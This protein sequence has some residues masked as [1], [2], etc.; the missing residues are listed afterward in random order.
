MNT[1]PF[2]TPQ[3]HNTLFF[4]VLIAERYVEAVLWQVHEGKIEIISQSAQNPW[5][6]DD[7]C[8]K[9]IDRSLQ[10]LGQLEEHVHQTLFAL[11]S[12]WVNSEGILASKKPLFQ[13]ITKE[14]ALEA[15]GFVVT[16]EALV[17]HLARTTSS[18]LTLFLLDFTDAAVNVILVK[19]G[20]IV[21]LEKVGRSG[22]TVSD[23]TEA[24]AHFQ[25]KVFPSKILLFSTFLSPEEISK[26]QQ[27][28]I[29]YTWESAY[30]FLHPPLVEI[31]ASQEIMN[32]VVQSGGMAVSEARGL[33][34][35]AAP[36]AAAPTHH[37]APAD[38]FGFKNTEAPP[39]KEIITQSLATI[40]PTQPP[41][42]EVK[43]KK[44]TNHLFFIFLGVLGGILVL[45]GVFYI[46]ASRLTKAVVTLSL[47]T[48]PVLKNVLLTLDPT[49]PQSDPT[50]LI[51]K[52][53]TVSQQEQEQK[54][55]DTT[56]VKIIGDKATG[57]VTL[58]NL[59]SSSKTFASGTHL[60]SGKFTYTLDQAVTVASSSSN[61]DPSTNSVVITPGKGD[62]TMTATVIGT[63]S[64]LGGPIDLTVESFD[65]KTYTARSTSGTMGG[66][67]REIQAVSQ[68]DKDN[69]LNAEKT[70]LLAKAALDFKA[71]NSPGTFALPS[72]K[73]K[74]LKAKYSA[75]VGTE[76]HT[77]GLDLQ[78][79]VD[80]LSYQLADVKPLV[81]QVL[82]SEL[83]DGYEFVSDDPQ[84]SSSPVQPASGSAQA[85]L[86]TN[87][88]L[89]S[90][91]KIDFENLK[92]NI[93][94]KSDKSA[95]TALQN[96]SGISS[97]SLKL[98]PN[99][100]N[101]FYHTVPKKTEDIKIIVG[102]Q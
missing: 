25:E 67:S 74:I 48:K 54:T 75:D 27:D 18:Q 93:A 51:L 83:S 38:H 95:V 96:T 100:F 15:V 49:A 65:K 61:Q 44:K 52:A 59:T 102:G 94:G 78:V 58:F 5:K 66:T 73:V 8:I 92:K 9:A 90:Q 41:F 82:T 72:G 34:K 88:S 6:R 98:L 21:K 36:S 47:T 37:L 68:Q 64:N 10:E 40:E 71:K 91:P 85:K 62:S 17:Q 53:T 20:E 56:G 23:I 28:L 19:H 81:T 99:I 60:S 24:F 70:D 97:V 42:F 87:I 2:S 32:L 55:A 22:D 4:A 69:L 33:L 46:M 57:K 63:D 89:M 101:F 30:P 76:T 1:H 29:G 84:I 79:Q 7:D 35:V 26:A 50:K 31:F 39:Q 80:G 14:L 16:T 13:R 43:K 12:E 77:V 3:L 86:D 45:C 11:R